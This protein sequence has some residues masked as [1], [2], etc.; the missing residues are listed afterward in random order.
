MMIKSSI[1]H[2][3][4]HCAYAGRIDV[5]AVLFLIVMESFVILRK[6]DK[7]VSSGIQ[8]SG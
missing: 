7:C 3:R 6:I 2:N 5:F 4:F 8:F 1:W